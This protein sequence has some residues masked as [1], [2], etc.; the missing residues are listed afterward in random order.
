MQLSRPIYQ[1]KRRARLLAREAA[2]RVDA[3][4]V[5]QREVVTLGDDPGVIDV[6]SGLLVNSN[7]EGMPMKIEKANLSLA[8][9]G[10]S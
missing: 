5:P 9:P 8:E 3:V 6:A 10:N 4:Q 7:F 1:L 2:G